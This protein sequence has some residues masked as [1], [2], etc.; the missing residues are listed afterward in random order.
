MDDSQ[1][2]FL[3][4]LEKE[5][6]KEAWDLKD[7]CTKYAFQGVAIVSAAYA[8]IGKGLSDNPNS[9]YFAFLFSIICIVLL[10]IITHK[11]GSSNRSYGYL[12]HLQRT[13]ETSLEKGQAVDR[14]T[15]ISA[16]NIESF[17]IPP[18]WM[19]A[20][21]FIGWEEVM[22]AW[23]VMQPSIYYK[24]YEDPLSEIRNSKEFRS[25]RSMDR[26][27][28]FHPRTHKIVSI[29]PTW[30]IF[31][32]ARYFLLST[33]KFLLSTSALV[34]GP[35]APRIKDCFLTNRTYRWYLPNVLIA[36]GTAYNSGAYLYRLSSI[37][38]LLA[39][40]GYLAMLYPVYFC[41]NPPENTEECLVLGTNLYGDNAFTYGF[42]LWIVFGIGWYYIVNR[43]QKKI[44][45]LET[46]LESIHS[47]S[48]IWQ[49]TVVAHFRALYFSSIIYGKPYYRYSF[50]L[51]VQAL[52]LINVC[53][54]NNIHDWVENQRPG[55]IYKILRERMEDI[56]SD[57][58]KKIL[59]E[60][61]KE[62]SSDEVNNK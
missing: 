11:Y 45:R 57:I 18:N 25:Y 29:F 21:R 56:N 55:E 2:K 60:K 61:L 52:H 42:N 39:L 26:L 8:V 1:Q 36:E 15:T 47:C 50:M 58:D 3:E 24:I 23:R 6:R 38:L 51:S 13:D 31:S 59:N 53:K 12:L 46:E 37:I 16:K 54:I 9:A 41:V 28:D 20:M 62:Y 32:P 35:F 30:W 40:I 33:S 4:N 34:K 17:S 14:H 44:Q 27:E 22:R 49:A 19:P 48:I 43:L 7:C 10:S 5:I